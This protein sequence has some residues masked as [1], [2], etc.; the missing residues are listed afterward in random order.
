MGQHLR[1]AGKGEIVQ[2]RALA[3][4]ICADPVLMAVL[5]GMQELGLPDALL[6]SGAIYNTV[7]NALTGRPPLTGIKDAD[8]VYFDDTDLSYEAEDAVI[9][10]AAVQFAGIPLPVEVRNQARVHLWFPQ[11]F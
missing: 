1:F 3:T 7:W 2:R 4:I 5:R 8:V 10:R 11:R 9:R 6:G